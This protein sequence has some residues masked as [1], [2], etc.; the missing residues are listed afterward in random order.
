[1]SSAAWTITG[2][3]DASS[4]AFRSVESI[5]LPVTFL[6]KAVANTSARTSNPEKW[7]T[8]ERHRIRHDEENEV[9]VKRVGVD[10]D[11][12]AQRWG[13]VYV[14][15]PFDSDVFALGELDEVLD[16]VDDLE[17]AQVVDRGNVARSEPAVFREGLASL[18]LVLV[19]AR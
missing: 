1:M 3:L 5:V 19:V 2:S 10:V 17:A 14:L 7:R 12:R 18:G 13:A 16:P 8:A 6:A 11:L 4:M 15:D 9:F